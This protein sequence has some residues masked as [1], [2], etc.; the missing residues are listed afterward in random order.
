MQVEEM[1]MLRYMGGY[2]KSNMIRNEDI[3]D[4]VRV[5]S[6]VDML[7]GFGHVKRRRVDA[8]VRRG[9]RFYILGPRRAEAERIRKCRGRVFSLRDEPEVA[10]VWLPNSDS[11]GL[12]MARAF[13]DFCLKD[14][15]LISVPE[16]SYRRLTGKDEFIV[17][18]TDG[19][20]DVLTND[21]VVKIVAS[22]SSRSSAARS[23]VESAVR[24]WRTK[25]PTS[26]V[27]DCAVVC[28]FL[29]S[30]S[31][32]LSTASNTK[33]S[34]KTVS[35]KANEVGAKIDDTSG[36]TAFPRSGT[37]REVEVS[38]EGN[39]VSEEEIEE[40]S[41]H[42]ELLSEVGAEWSALEGVSRLN[43]LLTLPRF[44]PDKDEN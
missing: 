19:I 7:R 4:K 2:T 44:V 37:V 10:R 34:D 29:D 13:G 42:E 32:N 12:A 33:D 38:G 39:D 30:N 5:T 11:P 16:I 35:M 3:W 24:A 23:L 20:W 40:A 31:N 22:A 43:T 8:P 36:P 41:E 26:K 28:L 9:E 6:M 1:R 15:G 14:F 27:D 21:E 18:A 25:Y 17:L